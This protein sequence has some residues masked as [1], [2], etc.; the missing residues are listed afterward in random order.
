MASC[1]LYSSP[2]RFHQLK[3]GV[4]Q[5]RRRASTGQ[6][7]TVESVTQRQTAPDNDRA[8]CLVSS[9]S[10]A[11]PLSDLV[12]RVLR[13]LFSTPVTRPTR[14]VIYRGTGKEKRA[15]F[16]RRLVISRL[17]CFVFL[18]IRHVSLYCSIR[19]EKSMNI[20]F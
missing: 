18:R 1:D 17:F 3:L 15:K 8:I 11:D 12:T 4:A 19:Q 20:F 10:R 14:R 2:M 6:Y 13:S 5:I 7:L 16:E 9:S